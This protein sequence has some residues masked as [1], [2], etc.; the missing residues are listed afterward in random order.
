MV[1]PTRPRYEVSADRQAAS[2]PVRYRETSHPEDGECTLCRL[3]TLPENK[4]AMSNPE[5]DEQFAAE[6]LIQ[7]IENQLTS[8]EPPF[9][10][11]VL[12]YL[13][14]TGHE[15]DA[16]VELM[17]LALAGE[18]RTMLAEERGF[19]LENYE[20]LLRALPELPQDSH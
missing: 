13:T 19:N 9:T 15:R 10:Q 20:R 7:A 1:K 8:G 14:L 17:A 2:R 12:N 4:P 18:I 16:S 11:A 6:T 5:D 3:D